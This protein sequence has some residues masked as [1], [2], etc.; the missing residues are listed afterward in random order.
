MRSDTT[1]EQF[2]ESLRNKEARRRIRVHLSDEQV[3]LVLSDPDLFTVTFSRW[4]MYGLI[5]GTGADPF[6]PGPAA[7]GAWERVDSGL[8]LPEE[9]DNSDH[10]SREATGSEGVDPPGRVS[11][12]VLGLLAVLFVA[13]PILALPL[14][15]SGWVNS[16]KALKALAFPARGRGLAIAGLTLS[17][18]A[19]SLTSLFM[20]L[21]IPGAWVRN[22]G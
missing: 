1:P 14:G 4:Q 11:G 6:G 20:L 19:V 17:I 9:P 22:F 15:I 2:R 12:F 21:A 18:V 10:H 16:N 5:A 8:L 13:I 7:L 3:A